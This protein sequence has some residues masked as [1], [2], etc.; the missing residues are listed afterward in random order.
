MVR[1]SPVM[2]GPIAPITVTSSSPELELLDPRYLRLHAAV[3][4]VAQMSGAAEYLH[5]HDRDME[6]MSVLAQDGSSSELL[7]SRLQ[8]LVLAPPKTA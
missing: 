5:K 1:G 4:R 8:R 6:Q 3:C 2:K 7:A